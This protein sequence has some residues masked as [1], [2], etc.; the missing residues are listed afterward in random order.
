MVGQLL[1]VQPDLPH[2]QWALT[3][4]EIR[5]DVLES[6][7]KK[8]GSLAKIPSR[9]PVYKEIYHSDTYFLLRGKVKIRSNSLKWACKFLG[10]EAKDTPFEFDTWYNAAKGDKKAL[11]EV[12]QHNIEDVISTEL[13]W[14]KMIPVKDHILNTCFLS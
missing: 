13:L 3:N 14:H 9:T 8:M 10:I 11:A 4:L 5:R 7:L 1:A 2:A 6:V 12:L